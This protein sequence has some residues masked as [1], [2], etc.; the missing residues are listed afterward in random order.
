MY[1]D[2]VLEMA[3]YMGQAQDMALM[4]DMVLVLDLDMVL[5][6]ALYMGLVLDMVL[7]LV[8]DMALV[9][10]MAL[11]VDMELE[12]YPQGKCIC[13]HSSPSYSILCH[14]GRDNQTACKHSHQRTHEG[15]P[16][17]YLQSTCS[18]HPTQEQR[19]L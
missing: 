15:S 12:L 17:V 19:A 7:V 4:L 6:M 9:Q 11:Y 13:Y 2:M 14:Q 18:N 3:L 10:D 1:M 16:Q 8:L 5:E